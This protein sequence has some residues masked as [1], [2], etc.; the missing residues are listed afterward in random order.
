MGARMGYERNP[1]AKEH[2]TPLNPNKRYKSQA[3]EYAQNE[4]GYVCV[5]R[6]PRIPGQPMDPI[7]AADADR[8]EEMYG[9]DDTDS[10]C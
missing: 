4:P 3:D 8:L 5:S 6:S 2:L 10:L 7:P 1:N 9:V